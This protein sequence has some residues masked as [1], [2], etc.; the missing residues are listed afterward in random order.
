MQD[1]GK[2]I[3]IA[4]EDWLRPLIRRCRDEH[5]YG[6]GRTEKRVTKDMYSWRVFRYRADEFEQKRD[7]RNFADRVEHFGQRYTVSVGSR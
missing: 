3:S 4:S 7:S 2:G 1:A 6:L 5:F